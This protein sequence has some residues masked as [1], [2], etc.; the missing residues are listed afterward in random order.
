MN[1]NDQQHTPETI[2]TLTRATPR[3]KIDAT[4]I[5]EIAQLCAK[6]MLT[7]S[8]AC[9]KLNIKPRTWFDWKSRCGRTGKFAEL[10]EAYRADRIESLI[11]RIDR[12]GA[13]G[14][15]GVKYPDWRRPWRCSKSLT[16]GVLETM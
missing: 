16:K 4:C 7:E 13:N 12:S 6:K 11:E 10:L 3:R 1:N 15:H 8:E 9:R 5:A 2:D 14:T